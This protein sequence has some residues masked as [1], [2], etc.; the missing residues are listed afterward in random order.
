LKK[1]RDVKNKFCKEIEAT[2]WQLEDLK[3]QASLNMGLTLIKEE[4][5]KDILEAWKL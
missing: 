3:K 1:E 5:K 2:Q 4:L